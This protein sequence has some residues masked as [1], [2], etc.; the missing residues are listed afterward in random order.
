MISRIVL[1]VA[2]P[3]TEQDISVVPVTL[4]NLVTSPHNV[5]TRSLEVLVPSVPLYTLGHCA[6][7]DEKG[8][9]VRLMAQCLRR[10]GLACESRKWIRRKGKEEEEGKGR[11]KERIGLYTT[12]S[13]VAETGSRFAVS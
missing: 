11:G 6:F 8:A 9:Y 1:V 10:K 13:G 12:R 2:M 5:F 4:P 7:Q 3:T